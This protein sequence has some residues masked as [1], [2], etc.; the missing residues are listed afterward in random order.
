MADN[1][2]KILLVEDDD[3]DVEMIHRAFK[4]A[5]I[6]NPI[7]HATDGMEALKILR[8]VDGQE[9]MVSPYL[10]LLDLNMPRMNGIE[11]LEELRSDEELKSSIVFV[12]TT[13]DDDRDII[14]AYNYHVA[15]YMVKSRAGD[16]FLELISML[17][18][19]WRVIEF[20]PVI[21]K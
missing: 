18:H 16:D 13:S 4:K 20:P 9:K 2:V 3:I 7:V 21:G 12:L 19:Y 10:I 14:D 11:L 5:K 1:T 17:N 15:G 6:S 8:G